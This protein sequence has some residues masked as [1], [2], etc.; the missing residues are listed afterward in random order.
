[1]SGVKIVSYV[2]IGRRK[3]KNELDFDRADFRYLLGRYYAGT[4]L[5]TY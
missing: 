5:G 3:G 1:M 4:Y 2:G